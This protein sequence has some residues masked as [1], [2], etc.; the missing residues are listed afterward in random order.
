MT[1]I[2]L[3]LIPS[4][5]KSTISISEQIEFRIDYS[6]HFV[7]YFLLGMLFIKGKQTIIHKNNLT[8]G[9]YMIL[10]ITFAILTEMVQKFITGRTY[11][12]VDMYNNIVGIISGFL[13]TILYFKR[14]INIPSKNN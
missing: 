8:K 4:T 13:I 7:T 14:K 1:V 11:N 6:E 5:P 10:W 12:P 2:I 9:I 3:S